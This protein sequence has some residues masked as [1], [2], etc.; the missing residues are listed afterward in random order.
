MQCFCYL[1]NVQDLL[2]DGRTPYERRLGEP[3]YGPTIPFGAVVAYNPISARD[4]SMLHQFGKKVSPGIFLGYELIAG[5]FWKGDIL[6]WKIW[7]SWTRQKIIL[8]EST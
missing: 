3:F 1:R 7:N 8:E 6:I 5:G 4:E 2:A